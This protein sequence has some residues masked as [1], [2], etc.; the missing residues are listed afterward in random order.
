MYNAQTAFVLKYTSASTGIVIDNTGDVGIGTTSPGAQLHIGK[1]ESVTAGEAGSIDRLFIQ[2]Y[3]NT[4]G[5]YKFTA[6][7]VNGSSDFLDLYYGGNPVMSWG[8]NGPSPAPAVVGIGTITPT[9][10]L[11]V[12]GFGSTSATTALDVENS[13]G[14]SLLT[15]RND[16]AVKLGTNGTFFSSIIR[17]SETKNNVSLA[18]SSNTSV[19]FTVSGALVGAT[20]FVSPASEL[21]NGILIASAR[22]SSNGTVTVQIYNDNASTTLSNTYY[23]TVINP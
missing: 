5:P 19:T 3:S 8:I 7:T 23:I 10:R 17:H 12:R 21:A 13:N 11:E 18:G 1:Q 20:V 14:T 2:P 16:G 6:R 15:V 22:V 9:A 4:G